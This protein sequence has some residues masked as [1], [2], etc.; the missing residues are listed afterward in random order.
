M[1]A[2]AADHQHEND[3]NANERD[4][5]KQVAV[6]PQHPMPRMATS[7]A[8]QP[9]QRQ[10]SFRLRLAVWRRWI[11]EIVQPQQAKRG[12]AIS[13]PR[14]PTA[15]HRHRVVDQHQRAN[16]EHQAEV[17]LEAQDRQLRRVGS[18]I[19]VLGRQQSKLH[20]L[21]ERQ[22]HPAGGWGHV[23]VALVVR[24]QR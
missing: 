1:A 5:P 12:A 14:G 10:Q 3:W 6:M 21:D 9:A 8:G 2:V 7:P 19:V 15:R 20:Q 24:E 18:R 23:L 16:A 13:A 4:G 17:R 11:D 22:R